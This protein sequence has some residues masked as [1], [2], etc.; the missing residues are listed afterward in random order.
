M[1]HRRYPF[2]FLLL[3]PGSLWNASATALIAAFALSAPRMSVMPS[4]M[5]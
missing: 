1:A 4:A 2:S 5:M 3:T